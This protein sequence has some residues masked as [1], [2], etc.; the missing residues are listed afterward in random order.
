MV[1]AYTWRLPRK[2]CRE[3]MTEL[4][5]VIPGGGVRKGKE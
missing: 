4:L 5:T 2:E 1:F 3:I